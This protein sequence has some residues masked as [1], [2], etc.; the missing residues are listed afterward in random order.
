MY[1][2]GAHGRTDEIVIP[3]MQRPFGNMKTEH[4]TAE[5]MR[6]MTAFSLCLFA[7]RF[8]NTVRNFFSGKISRSHAI[9]A[10]SEEANRFRKRRSHDRRPASAVEA[11]LVM[12]A[13]TAE[14]NRGIS[15]RI[16]LSPIRTG[17]SGQDNHSVRRCK[18][19]YDPVDRSLDKH[20]FCTVV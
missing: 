20:I 4:R 10:P 13:H 7:P 14:K 19:C 3:S 5:R 18:P 12:M 16:R 1:K 11:L 8:K 17:T 2:P 15:F 9:V 6:L